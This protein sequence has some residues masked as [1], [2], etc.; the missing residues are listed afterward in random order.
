MYFLYFSWN[1]QCLIE[2][3]KCFS[4]WHLIAKCIKFCRESVR[5]LEYF[6]VLVRKQLKLPDSTRPKKMVYYSH[7]STIIFKKSDKFIAFLRFL[8]FHSGILQKP[9]VPSIGCR[10]VKHVV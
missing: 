4:R 10:I 9:G 7:T 2:V 3:F 1:L 5:V 8:S 6:R